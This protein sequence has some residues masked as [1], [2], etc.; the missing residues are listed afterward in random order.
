M[1]IKNEIWFCHTHRREAEHVC[2][3]GIHSC[4]DGF[5]GCISSPY[6]ISSSSIYAERQCVEWGNTGSNEPP[7]EASK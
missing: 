2:S 5:V 3:S 6:N 4:G 7:K 1:N